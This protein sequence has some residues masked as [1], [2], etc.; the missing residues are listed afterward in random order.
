[1]VCGINQVP[2]G[3]ATPENFYYNGA[4]DIGF[5]G[6]KSDQPFLESSKQVTFSVIRAPD[7]LHILVVYDDPSDDN[8]GAITV[9]LTGDD[10]TNKLSFSDSNREGESYAT[11]AMTHHWG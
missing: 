9:D 2:T 8:R 3:G 11:G 5:N 6:F 4:T 7:G 1:M 10:L